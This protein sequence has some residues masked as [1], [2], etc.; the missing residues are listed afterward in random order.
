[1][2]FVIE[3]IQWT[4]NLQKTVN[5]LFL[6]THGRKRDGGRFKYGG[7]LITYSETNKQTQKAKQNQVFFPPV[8]EWNQTQR[9][10]GETTASLV[11]LGGLGLGRIL[12][13]VIKWLSLRSEKEN[14]MWSLYMFH[15]WLWV[16]IFCMKVRHCYGKSNVWFKWIKSMNRL[17]QVGVG[18]INHKLC[19]LLPLAFH[20]YKY[21]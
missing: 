4:V 13:F 17:F 11:C 8:E 5:F 15:F 9:F 10:L 3:D 14:F 20:H 21:F 6:E 18:I 12:K 1:M 19:H 2:L 7:S 16:N